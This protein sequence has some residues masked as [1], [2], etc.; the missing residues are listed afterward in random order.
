MQLVHRV[1]GFLSQRHGNN[2]GVH[3]GLF[4][5]APTDFHAPLV[6]SAPE[7][8]LV[9]P[10]VRTDISCIWCHL[11]CFQPSWSS[12]CASKQQPQ[13]L[14]LWTTKIGFFFLHQHES[15]FWH[16]M[17]KGTCS[18]VVHA[19]EEKLT[20]GWAWQ[21]FNK[22]QEAFLCPLMQLVL[23]D[24]NPTNTHFRAYMYVM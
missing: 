2:C 13:K 20:E 11:N 10:I 18:P 22:L 5:F 4:P 6:L 17:P 12:S 15:A 21:Q 7:L 24:H 23:G 8:L 14:H 16:K 3:S 1:N 9:A 19:V